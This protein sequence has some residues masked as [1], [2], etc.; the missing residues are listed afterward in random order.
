MDFSQKFKGDTIFFSVPNSEA[1][2]FETFK[3]VE[4]DT[5][6][7]KER[8]KKRNPE[9]HKHYKLINNFCP[10]PGWGVNS[11]RQYTPGTT[12]EKCLF[13]IRGTLTE[14]VQYLG[15]FNYILLEDVASGKVIKWDYSNN[16]NNGLIIFSPSILRHLSL[17]KGLDFLIAENDSTF[18]PVKCHDVAFSILVKHKLLLI[19]VDTDFS[20]DKGIK[21][22]HNWNPMFFLKKD[23]DKLPT[24]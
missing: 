15:R 3:L 16:E 18:N 7:L 23:E 6:W 21:T 14:D 22:S 4:P 1:A 11:H 10:V 12:L 9:Q 13:I 8:P 20:T 24:N 5:L 17:M 19:S 2:Y